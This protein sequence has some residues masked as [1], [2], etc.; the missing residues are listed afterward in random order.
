L[1]CAGV[2]AWRVGRSVRLFHGGVFP[3]GW[4][5]PGG[6][7]V[8]A[9]AQRSCHAG[10]QGQS[11]GRCSTSRRAEVATRAGMATSWV[12]R[13]A[14]RAFACRAPAA[15]AAARSRLNAMQARASQAPLA[16]K[17]PEGA[18]ASGPSFSSAMTCSMM[19]WSRCVSLAAT[20]VRVLL[21]TNPW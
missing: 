7:V 8:V 13:V 5:W 16:W 3:R 4:L 15:A 19:A 9:V 20:V 2:L 1:S 12:R 17:R 11:V 18:W 14:Q 21:V 6:Q 10:A